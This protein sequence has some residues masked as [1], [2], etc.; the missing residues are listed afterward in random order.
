[1]TNDGTFVEL[2]HRGNALDE[3]VSQRDGRVLSVQGLAGK[4]DEE[5][6]GERAVGPR[7]RRE[8]LLAPSGER[9]NRN[10]SNQLSSAP[11]PVKIAPRRSDFGVRRLQE[12][13]APR[14]LP[15]GHS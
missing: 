15:G 8:R 14:I 11:E 10:L 3:G 13:P 1:M 9:R 4:I 6:V 7:H 5:A 2:A 12:E